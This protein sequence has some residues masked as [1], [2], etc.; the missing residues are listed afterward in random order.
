[1]SIKATGILLA[2]GKSRRMGT[3]KGLVLLNGKPL[4]SYALAVLEQCCD[5]ILIAGINANQYLTRYTIVEDMFPD[6]GP[7]AG[8][9]AALHEASNQ[10]C[11]V[12]SVDLPFVDIT[13]VNYLLN[14]LGDAMA[15][16]PVHTDGKVEPLC[17]VYRRNCIHA[18]EKA[19]ATGQNKMLDILNSLNFKQ[20]DIS[21]THP[22]FDPIVFSNINTPDDLAQAHTLIGAFPKKSQLK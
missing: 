8:I 4:Y 10:V 11:I 16:A 18:F 20:L 22:S 5:E 14:N 7:G 9:H 1:M 15:V 3:D 12:L 17:A 13:L 6:Q 21:S 2:G 19:L